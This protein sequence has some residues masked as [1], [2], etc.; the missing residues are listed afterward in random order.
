M[1]VLD[2]ATDAPLGDGRF[3]SVVDRPRTVDALREAVARRTG[4]GLAIYPQG[5]RTSLD[6]GGV[7]ARPGAAIDVTRLSEVID[8]PAADMTITAGA[9]MTLAALQQTLSNEGQRLPLD[10]PFPD[11]ATL[12]G[13]WATNTSGPRRFGAGRPRDMIIGIGFVTADGE[14]VK[15]GGR[16][17]KNVAGYDFPKLLTGSMGT[18]GIIT[19]LTLKVRPKPETSAVAWVPYFDID[20]LDADLAALGTSATRPVAVELL[21][22][23]AARAVGEAR[24]LEGDDFVLAIGFEDNAHSVAWQLDRLR[25]EMPGR[26]GDFRT[27]MDDEADPIWQSLTSFQAATPGAISIT[28]N[29][30]PS[31]VVPFVRSLKPG[32]WS[33]QAHAGN[34]IVRAH[35]L[36]E[37]I[38]EVIGPELDALRERAV[39]A[40]GNLVVTRCPAAWKDRLSVWGRRRGD[41]ALMEK[42]K[43]ALDPGHVMNPGRFVGRI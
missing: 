25:F 17:V 10:A 13:I 5:G 29:L 34:G 21:N 28:A 3:A 1:S 39:A 15:G 36:G 19:H 33:V 20:R 7:P 23:S 9:G 32:R 30:T 2:A 11:R 38:L 42:L 12:G 26:A 35:S 24:G 14:A 16:V 31:Q 6:Y 4:E 40:G 41:W 18:L 43:A 37:S 8:Y 27:V 22:R